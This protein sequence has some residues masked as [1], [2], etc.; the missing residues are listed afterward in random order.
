MPSG[1]VRVR[2]FSGGTAPVAKRELR[3]ANPKR[4]PSSSGKTITAI[5]REGSNPSFFKAATADSALTTPSGPSKLPPPGTESRWL[6]V[7]IALVRSLLGVSHHAQKIPLR[8]C[9]TSSPSD[10]ALLMN[11]WF[12]CC[13]GAENTG[14]LYLPL[15]GTVPISAISLSSALGVILMV[16]VMVRPPGGIVAGGRERVRVVVECWCW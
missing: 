7:P 4:E 3:Q 9:A 5:G 15:T 10:V 2:T 16:L 14:R 1:S 11:H 12:S 8:S 6:P 13:S